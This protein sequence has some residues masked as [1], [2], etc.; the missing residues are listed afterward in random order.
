[1]ASIPEGPDT[2]F[3]ISPGAE[4]DLECFAVH[5]GD[6]GGRLDPHFH[7]PRFHSLVQ[8]LRDVGSKPLGSLAKYSEEAWDKSD[9]R[10][11]DVFPYIEISGVGLGT[12]EYDLAETLVS[13]APSRARQ[14]V[15]ADDILVSL[16]RPHRGAV[17][18]VQPEHDGA[19]ASTGFAVVR[20]VDSEQIDREYLSMC[21]TASFGCDQMFMRSSGGNYPAITKEKLSQ[22]LIPCVSLESQRNL[23]AAMNTARADRKAKQAEADALLAGLDDFLLE[24]LGLTLPPDDPRRVF[25]V[26][27]AELRAQ[28]RLNSD[29]FHPERILAL[30]KL[31]AAAENLMVAPL[32]ELVSFE[33][34]QIKTPSK[35]YL[36]LAHVQ[37][38]TGELTHATDTASGNSFTYQINDVLFARLR[39]YLNK[40]YRAEM[41]GC[42]SPEFHVLRVKDRKSLLS[43]YLATVLRSR[44]VLAQTI[45]MMTGNTHPRLTNDDVANLK[46]PIPGLEIQGTIAAEDRRLRLAARRLR[47]EAEAGWRAAKRWFEDQLLGA[48][49]P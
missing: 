23:V 10:F 30:R 3:C 45:H 44:L 12:N 38:D 5:R 29:Y 31:S 41:N 8:T 17:A 42:C 13:E 32:A 24:T 40:V 11:T 33:R 49:T 4:G 25:A 22:V 21:L 39:P 36:S 46:I 9:R 37:S 14:V 43:D 35:N 34:T 27:V 18:L 26:R 2:F 1:M 6:E 28:R 19:I 16:T 15:R 7:K 47:T 20:D 48:A